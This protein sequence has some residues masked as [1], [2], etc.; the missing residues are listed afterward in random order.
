MSTYLDIIDGIYSGNLSMPN[1][2]DTFE[3]FDEW[4]R[5]EKPEEDFSFYN[6]EQFKKVQEI[7]GVSK[8]EFCKLADIS[9]EK[10]NEFLSHEKYLKSNE[11]YMSFIN[12]MKALDIQYAGFDVNDEI[13]FKD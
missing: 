9:L 8:E 3:K 11:E 7:S 4:M 10:L 13:V 6:S 12:T 1:G 2:I 5:S